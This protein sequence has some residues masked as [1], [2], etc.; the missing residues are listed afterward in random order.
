MLVNPVHCRKKPNGT[1]ISSCK[2]YHETNL[3]CQS[4]SIPPPPVHS[5]GQGNH[6]YAD[7]FSNMLHPAWRKEQKKLSQCTVNVRSVYGQCTHDMAWLSRLLFVSVSGRWSRRGHRHVRYSI[8]LS[9]WGVGLEGVPTKTLPSIRSG[10]TED[11][12][13]SSHIPTL[14]DPNLCKNSHANE[15]P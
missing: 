5:N 11:Q 2:I 14:L 6:W 7:T 10:I 9:A 4:P 12:S 15:S 3:F 8:G 1:F 13:S